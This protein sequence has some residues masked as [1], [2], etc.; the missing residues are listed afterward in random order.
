MAHRKWK[1]SKQ[2]PSLLPGPAVPG[3]CLVSLHFLWAILCPQA[4]TFLA[5]PSVPSLRVPDG[6]IS[7]HS[8]D[9]VSFMA[10]SCAG[11]CHVAKYVRKARQIAAA[12]STTSATSAISTTSAGNRR[13]RH[14]QNR[15]FVRHK[16]SQPHTTYVFQ[17]PFQEGNFCR[18][19]T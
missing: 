6:D 2:L 3:S 15:V 11:A 4:V 5:T 18:P 19:K 17:K 9:Y 16:W 7:D 1:E 14:P 8:C 12:A 10:V 13:R